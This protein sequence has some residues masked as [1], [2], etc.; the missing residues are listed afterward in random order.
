[1]YK[2]FGSYKQ[3]TVQKAPLRVKLNRLMIIQRSHVFT[4]IDTQ[5]WSNTVKKWFYIINS[6]NIH[7]PC[8][9]QTKPNLSI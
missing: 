3:C 6:Q 2:E 9:K 5:I 7:I 1:M 4:N 8:S